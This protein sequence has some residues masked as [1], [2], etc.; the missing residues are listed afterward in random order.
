MTT[1]KDPLD[2][3]IPEDFTRLL[4]GLY[5]DPEQTLREAAKNL[6]AKREAKRLAQKRKRRK[7]P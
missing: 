4:D 7:N 3:P 2:E 1:T 5:D 6:R